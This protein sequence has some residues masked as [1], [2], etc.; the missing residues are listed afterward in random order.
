MKRKLFLFAI[1]L[2][3]AI[4][5][6]AVRVRAASNW[7]V[8]KAGCAAGA[9]SNSNNG[10]SRTSA[11]LTI[12]AAAALMVGGDTLT[13]GN[14]IWNERIYNI[15]PSGSSAAP[16]IVKAENQNQAILQ[17]NNGT[18][19]DGS[20]FYIVAITTNTQYITFDGLVADGTFTT[21]PITFQLA[22][23]NVNDRIDHIVFKNGIC[24]NALADPSSGGVC[25]IVGGHDLP[26][27]HT[28]NSILN[29]EVYGATARPQARDLGGYGIYISGAQSTL[30]DGNYL[31][32]NEGF[33]IELFDNA[34]DMNN[35]VV[36]NNTLRGMAGNVD[37]TLGIHAAINTLIYN[38]VIYNSSVGGVNIGYQSTGTRF[39]NNLVYNSVGIGVRID[40]T[41][42][43]APASTVVQNNVIFG[44]GTNVPLDGGTSST[45]SNNVFVNPGVVS[46]TSGSEN[47]R[48]AAAS[49][50]AFGTGLVLNSFFTKDA[51]GVTRGST[52]EIGPYEFTPTFW[53]AKTGCTAGVCS[54]SNNGLTRTTAKL[55]VNAGIAIMS[56]CSTL[57]IGDGTYGERISEV[58]GAT[59]PSCTTGGYTTLKAEHR[60]LAIMRPSDAVLQDS[61]FWVISV[62]N[63][64]HHIVFD[65]I[66]ADG[67]ATF[68]EGYQ[69]AS[70]ASNTVAHDIIIKNGKAINNRSN[71]AV[72]GQDGD[73][74]HL[75]SHVNLVYNML[76]QN[77]ESAFNQGASL[78]VLNPDQGG[79]GIYFIA[80]DSVI[81]N[82][83]I[84]NNYSLGITMW[85]SQA[86]SNINNDIIRNNDIYDNAQ[87]DGIQITRQTT[88][89]LVHNNRI[90][91]NGG[92]GIYSY[93][94]TNAG[95]YNNVIYGNS[96]WGISLESQFGPPVG[97]II[98]NNIIV[99][100]TSGTIQDQGTST[101]A[102]VNLFAN[103]GFISPNT[104]IPN[105]RLSSA[106]NPAVGQGLVLNNL[107][108]K[109]ADDVTRGSVWDIGPYEFAG[110]S[111]PLPPGKTMDSTRVIR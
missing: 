36:S 73:G 19:G 58:T 68:G 30:V 27:G 12:A 51:D 83:D 25:I 100:N 39:Y 77:F 82:C 101:S 104:T 8:A 44:N 62:T 53:V 29:N 47:F 96:G 71:D 15:I 31:H 110:S 97:T 13:I 109:D 3:I 88:N 74:V 17:P 106:S 65:G 95:I 20:T 64:A 24:R 32:D 70:E 9:C 7:F 26:N 108:L 66:V 63:A 102:S 46:L 42:R 11:K 105:F 78:G 61:W 72:N 49:G 16:T 33:Q 10:N 41:F 23:G 55:T 86:G 92:K 14:G 5:P 103:P 40:P 52:W 2:A 89:L 48:L 81:E 75:G 50:P 35:N 99:N 34:L 45:I 94:A 107:F 90:F 56:A 6:T 57:T 1:V 59:I 80:R 87:R 69:I 54:D 60:N 22:T 84:H 98:R 111:I 28:N 76:I 37:E 79:Y 4:V 67:A 91:R 93:A 18:I 85:N 43:G 38:N 21:A